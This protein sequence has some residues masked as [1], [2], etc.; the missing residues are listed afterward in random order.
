MLE[1]VGFLVVK[2]S[3]KLCLRLKPLRKRKSRRKDPF[4]SGR[5]VPA[6]E[7]WLIYGALAMY[8]D[9]GIVLD[10]TLLFNLGKKRKTEGVN[11]TLGYL[12]LEQV[13]IMGQA[14][15]LRGKALQTNNRFVMLWN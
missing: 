1:K 4:S 5:I 12:Y 9:Q 11:T 14:L 8:H 6:I 2:K 10:K 13:L 7:K 3:Q 15:T